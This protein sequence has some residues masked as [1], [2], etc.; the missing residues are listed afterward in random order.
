MP[1]L[2]LTNKSMKMD[3][4]ESNHSFHSGKCSHL[5]KVMRNRKKKPS[6]SEEADLLLFIFITN[7]EKKNVWI[8]IKTKVKCC[9]YWWKRHYLFH[10]DGSTM[11]I[12]WRC[13][14]HWSEKIYIKKLSIKFP[15]THF[16]YN[17]IQKCSLHIAAQSH[18][19]TASFSLVGSRDR[20]SLELAP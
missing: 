6:L 7:T 9:L 18:T 10:W 14:C 2:T 20:C 16:S 5:L 1:R 13:L 17:I 12:L 15:L 4:E 3:V 8:V 19:W 11:H